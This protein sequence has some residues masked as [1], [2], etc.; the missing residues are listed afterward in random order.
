MT[1]KVKIQIAKMYKQRLMT[2]LENRDL[3]R[4]EKCHSE[5]DGIITVKINNWNNNKKKATIQR[6]CF[7]CCRKHRHDIDWIGSFWKDI[8]N[9]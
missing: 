4:C 7:D 5:S 2:R 8:F 1:N 9:Y 3:M 6:L